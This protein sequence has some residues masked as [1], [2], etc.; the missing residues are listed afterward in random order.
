MKYLLAC[1]I[2]F[3]G[4]VAYADEEY[5]ELPLTEFTTTT[6][7]VGGHFINYGEG[8]YEW[9]YMTAE[10]SR[11]FKLE[12]MT[13]NGNL[14]W[15]ELTAERFAS[16]SLDENVSALTFGEASEAEGIYQTLESRT[17]DVKG[18]FINFGDDPYAWLYVTHDTSLMAKLTGMDDQGYLTWQIY[19]RG[20]FADVAFSDHNTVAV[21]Q[22]IPL[23]WV[24]P[25]DNGA[26]AMFMDHS[27]IGEWDVDIDWLVDKFVLNSDG[28]T[29]YSYHDTGGIGLSLAPANGTYGTELWLLSES[30]FVARFLSVASASC[31][32][33]EYYAL[34]QY[35]QKWLLSSLG[36]R[37]IC[38][39]SDSEAHE[40]L[41]ASIIEYG[42]ETETGY[43]Y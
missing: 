7:P 34:T 31:Y 30:F 12:G 8:A 22:T 17:F 24:S 4:I 18:H 43:F 9:I 35:E 41:K 40:E 23:E 38:K 27:L 32:R 14:A 16:I 26:D 39:T 36:P 19:P 11:L 6:M 33:V 20:L 15:M 10:T 3:V 21:I 29:L 25:G 37:V 13:Q 5:S 1:F 2:C 28:T 42:T